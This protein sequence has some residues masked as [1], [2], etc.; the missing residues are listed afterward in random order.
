MTGPGRPRRE[1]ESNAVASRPWPQQFSR[2]LV[3]AEL[4][5]AHVLLDV[6]EHQ[7]RSATNRGYCRALQIYEV[8]VQALDEAS[9]SWSD[10]TD[11]P[12][13]ALRVRLDRYATEI[14]VAS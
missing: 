12:I 3:D 4:D 2:D 10:D 6:A 5:L 11:A 13:Q 14:P 7:E 9:P 8:M 1:A